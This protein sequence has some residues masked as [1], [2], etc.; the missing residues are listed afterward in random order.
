MLLDWGRYFPEIR[1]SGELADL[2][3]S[4][5]GPRVEETPA[6]T[7]AYSQ[8]EP[9][10]TL[11]RILTDV[12]AKAPLI[13]FPAYFVTDVLNELVVA[14]GGWSL[15]APDD[16][17]ARKLLEPLLISLSEL[18]MRA[19]IT[20]LH[21]ASRRAELVGDTPEERYADFVGRL[22][23]AEYRTSFAERYPLLLADLR[24]AAANHGTAVRRVLG[25]AQTDWAELTRTFPGLAEAGPLV[26]L[27]FGRGDRHR[28]GAAVTILGFES[29]YEPG[30][31]RDVRDPL[32]PLRRP[33]RARLARVRREDR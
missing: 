9:S 19:I 20:D 29:G 28:D 30:T 26:R 7:Y 5:W 2:V 12:G 32:S 22:A 11:S 3:E 4:T 17:V 14:A 10:A 21:A 18:S 25:A 16:D 6:R 31:A 23:M 13:R 8:D 1:T 15:F 24:R 33:R 27:D